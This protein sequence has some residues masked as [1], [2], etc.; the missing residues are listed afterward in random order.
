MD[1]VSINKYAKNQLAT[2]RQK[3]ILSD[4]VSFYKYTQKQV[5][6][7]KEQADTTCGYLSLNR[8]ERFSNILP[9]VFHF[10]GV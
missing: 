7:V 9:N 5:I 1:L 10:F 8:K 2:L 4:E 6:C 3:Q